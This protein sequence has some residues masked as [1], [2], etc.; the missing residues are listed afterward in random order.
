MHNGSPLTNTELI[1]TP[2]DDDPSDYCMVAGLLVA[3]QV[4]PSLGMMLATTDKGI[5]SVNVTN[6]TDASMA[7]EAGDGLFT[8]RRADARRVQCSNVPDRI[9]TSLSDEEKDVVAAY[10]VALG[11]AVNPLC[12]AGLRDDVTDD[13]QPAFRGG[14]G[15]RVQVSGACVVDHATNHT[16]YPAR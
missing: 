4:D 2:D 8:L 6:T 3:R 1:W 7:F 12:T 11:S 15:S 5:V 14:R 16:A 10:Q 13:S 9:W